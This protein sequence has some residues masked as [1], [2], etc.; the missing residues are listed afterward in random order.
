MNDIKCKYCKKV[1]YKNKRS[2]S[3]HIARYHS[4][5]KI[6]D[7]F[8]HIRTPLKFIRLVQRRRHW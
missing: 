6:K 5:K 7:Q 1:G 8:S 4:N 2:L 3:T